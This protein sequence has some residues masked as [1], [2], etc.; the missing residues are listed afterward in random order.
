MGETRWL[1]SLPD[2]PAA[3]V[4]YADLSLG[5]DVL[6]VLLAHRAAAPTFRGVRHMLAH[7]PA[8]SVMNFCEDP[9]MAGRASFGRGM[10][11]LAA[12]ELCFDAWAYSHQL[13]SVADL[14]VRSSDVSIV[15]CHGGTPVGYGGDFGGVGA[16]RGERD[17]I[18]AEWRDG[19]SAVAAAGNTLVKLSGFLMPVLGF[20]FEHRST[21]PGVA[22]LVDV[23][24]PLVRHCIEAFGTDRCMFASNFPVDKVSADYGTIVEAMLEL[25]AGEGH[26]D[27]Q[28]VFAGTAKR[29]YRL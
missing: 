24:G 29:F 8:S 17:R 19:V 22:E 10:K 20:G 21:K 2:P 6:P 16:T 26:A 9:S 4:G 7:H 25:T 13:K 18:A 23:L 5:D 27:R 3:I 12:Q 14:A 1:A 15:L 11:Q 28:A